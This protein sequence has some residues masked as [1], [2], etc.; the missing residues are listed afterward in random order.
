[1][2]NSGKILVGPGKERFGREDLLALFAEE[3]AEQAPS[4]AIERSF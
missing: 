2:D 3:D 1:M 4:K